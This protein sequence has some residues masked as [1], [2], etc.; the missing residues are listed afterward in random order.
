MT[1]ADLRQLVA[2]APRYMPPAQSRD[3]ELVLQRGSEFVAKFRPPQWTVEGIAQRG[4]L[5]SVTAPTGHGKTAVATLLQACCTSGRPF[6]GR[7]VV[8]GRVLA[9]CGE[10]PTDYAARLLATLAILGLDKSALDNLAVLD[11]LVNL[12]DDYARIDEA[13]AAFGELVL[14]FVDTSVAYYVGDD[15]NSNT[16][17]Q[18]HA[19]A[20]RGLTRLPGNPT[21]FVLCH[22]TKGATAEG[23]QPRGGGAFLAEVD[24][25]LTLWRTGALVTLHWAG[26]LRGPEFEP[27]RFELLPQSLG[28]PDERGRDVMSV[29]ALPAGADRAEALEVAKLTD[30][31]RLLVAMQRRPGASVAELALA[32]GFTHGTGAPTKSRAHSLLRALKAQKLAT[33]GRGGGWKLTRAGAAAAAEAA[34]MAER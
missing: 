11:R 3:G 9:L 8:Q 28:L 2:S 22:P 17:M 19:A 1:I 20:L 29:A 18:R 12:T 10:N 16:S 6:A 32:A 13:V 23:L 26:K 4:F 24:G 15:E 7:E 31:N 27:L 5:Y 14:V 34:E 33:Q 25:N 30:E 21:V